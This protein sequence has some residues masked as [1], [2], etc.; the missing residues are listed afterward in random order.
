[1]DSGKNVDGKFLYVIKLRTRD[2]GL[3]A[4]LSESHETW[5]FRYVKKTSQFVNPVSIF[6]LYKLG[7]DC[8]ISEDDA[9]DN[10]IVLTWKE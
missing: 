1:M 7:L 9:V 2:I 8:Y 5:I 4:S 3:L 10:V 6:F